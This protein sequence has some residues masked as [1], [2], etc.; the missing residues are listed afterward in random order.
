[1]MNEL[2]NDAIKSMKLLNFLRGFYFRKS[3]KKTGV[4]RGQFPIL[5]YLTE[6]ENCSQIELSKNFHISA[7]AI[8]KTLNR[9]DKAGMVVKCID[10]NNKRANTITI[11]DLGRETVLNAEKYFEE[12][13]TM[14]FKHFD[15][16]EFQEFKRLIDKC[17]KGLCG[18]EVD[19]NN[20]FQIV[21][22]F[23]REDDE[24]D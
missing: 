16:A 7:A 1:M 13:D 15:E 10:E 24:H 2:T 3:M 8:T 18:K 12:I 5:K 17:I 21:E 6:H 9:L 11:T 19:D 22:E 20:Y 14:T 23:M 4:Y